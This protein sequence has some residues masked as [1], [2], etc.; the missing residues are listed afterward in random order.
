MKPE[1]GVVLAVLAV[2]G[3]S[4]FWRKE[5]LPIP[6]ILTGL[7][8]ILWKACFRK[9]AVWLILGYMVPGLLLMI[10]SR[11]THEKIGL[12]DGLVIC[13][14]GIWLGFFE[15]LHMLTWSLL[16]AAVAAAGLLLLKSNKKEISFVPFLLITF[17][18]ERILP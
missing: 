5:I 2:N 1:E 11:I 15:T 4:D 10:L 8:G 16:L 3:A 7:L 17:L 18:M 12:G 9:E 6:T 13:T 14:S